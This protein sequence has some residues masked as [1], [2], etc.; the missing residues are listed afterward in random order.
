MLKQLEK[1]YDFHFEKL[2]WYKN[3]T[4]FHTIISLGFIV[5][6]VFAFKS[7]ILDA[8][9]IPSGSMKPT[10]KIG[11]FL[12]VNKMRYSLKVPFTNIELSRLD[13]PRRGDIVTFT[14]PR[15][16][17]KAEASDSYRQCVDLNGK[18]LVKR[19]VGL[20]GDDIKVLDKEIYLNGFKYETTELTEK[21]DRAVLDDMD[22]QAGGPGGPISKCYSENRAKNL[23]KEKIVD[24][25][26]KEVLTHYIIR[27]GFKD[28]DYQCE[29][30]ETTQFA[31]DPTL[32]CTPWSGPIPEGKYLVMGDNRNHSFDS[33]AW[34]LVD[35]AQIH[36]KVY[37]SYF[38]VYWGIRYT[39][40][41]LQSNPLWLFG[42]WVTRKRTDISVRGDRIFKRIY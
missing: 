32:A 18:T 31:D 3:N 13:E 36:G 11:D 17:P 38:S 40:N 6:W 23:Y 27:D 21:A 37:M 33:T 29:C 15:F 4:F 7:S 39:N 16:R 20:P 10:L 34:G 25:D 26:N 14:P 1:F 22:C 19:V 2:S 12:F 8:N 41:T 42:E 28:S 35:R 30:N 9:N 24:R 5:L